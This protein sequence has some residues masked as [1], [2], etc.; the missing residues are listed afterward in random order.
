MPQKSRKRC[1]NREAGIIITS[2]NFRYFH[3][4]F[5]VFL[6]KHKFPSR[7]VPPYDSPETTTAA[8]QLN[9]SAS[10]NSK[11][12]SLLRY[13]ANIQHPIQDSG[14]PVHKPPD[15][16]KVQSIIDK[17]KN[18]DFF[19]LDEEEKETAK[20]EDLLAM[21]CGQV[22]RSS[23]NV[24]DHHKMVKKQKRKSNG[25]FDRGFEDMKF[26]FP[27]VKV[28]PSSDEKA[29]E[30]EENPAEDPQVAQPSEDEKLLGDLN[31]FESKLSGEQRMDISDFLDHIRDKP[32]PFRFDTTPFMQT[33][34]DKLKRP[35]LEREHQDEEPEDETLLGFRKFFDFDSAPVKRSLSA[36]TFEDS[37]KIA[38]LKSKLIAEYRQHHPIIDYSDI[39][40]QSEAKNHRKTDNHDDDFLDLSYR[41]NDGS[42][43]LNEVLKPFRTKERVMSP[44]ELHLKLQL[45][46]EFKELSPLDLKEPKTDARSGSNKID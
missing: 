12:E 39:L 8:S 30:L 21:P 34:M 37:H 38:E 11:R 5:C 32:K 14:R 23:R 15:L 7:A 2:D 31:R 18:V 28:G 33:E 3:K 24:F 9:S 13:L 44:Y 40:R 41:L 16:H 4:F 6:A 27:V 29:R 42:S 35:N 19:N 26:A 17:I 1:R 46:N 25:L 36:E 20:P 45:D 10:Y 22:K 43:R